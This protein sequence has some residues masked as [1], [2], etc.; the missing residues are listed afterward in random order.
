MHIPIAKHPAQENPL[1]LIIESS[2]QGIRK[3]TNCVNHFTPV[4]IGVLGTNSIM[5]SSRDFGL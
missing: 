3:W 1:L 4:F 5:N 2:P